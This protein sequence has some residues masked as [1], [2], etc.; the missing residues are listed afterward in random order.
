MLNKKD[1]NKLEFENLVKKIHQVNQGWHCF[2]LSNKFL[3]IENRYLESY[4]RKQKNLL[5][6]EL[7]E[8]FPQMI[9]KKIEDNRYS[10]LIKD[11]YQFDTYKDA[12]HTE[13]IK[14]KSDDGTH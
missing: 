1:N 2:E 5:Q 10:L 4:Y 3:N 13:T 12:C 14:D 9:E 7:L 8:K 6:N 11:E